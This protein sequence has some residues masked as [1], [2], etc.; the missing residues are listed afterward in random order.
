[1]PGYRA[2]GMNP[3]IRGYSGGQQRAWLEAELAA[4]RGAPGID[5][6]V[7]CMHQVV[8]STAHF[9]GAD[10]GLRR[11]FAPL[12]D[13]YGVDLIVAGH[14]HLFER[15][16][17]VRGV[18]PG[19]ALL[20]PA[21]KGTN[22]AEMDT[23]NGYVQMTIGGGGNSHPTQRKAWA[24]PHY[25]VVTVGITPGGPM[26]QRKHIHQV[27]PAPW[28]AYRDM[29]TPYGFA[30]FDVEPAEPGGTTSITVTHYG[31]AR[32]SRVYSPLDRFVMRKPVSSAARTGPRELVLR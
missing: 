10:L 5:W 21:A 13:R 31:A 27:E 9:N 8:M 18:L 6:I 17:P 28:S 4:A 7:V 24:R 3:Y 14:E 26:S 23:R 2:K 30:S 25:G 22:P 29:K 20:T 19:S 32:G 1:M 15:T 12:F 16:F 11:E